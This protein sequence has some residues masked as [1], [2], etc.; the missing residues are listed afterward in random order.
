VKGFKFSHIPSRITKIRYAKIIRPFKE[1]LGKILERYRLLLLIE[2]AIYAIVFSVCVVL[3]YFSFHTYAFDLGIYNQV[4][5]TT[6]Y[7]GKLLFTPLELLANPSGSLFGVHFS[8]IFLG[9]M[10]IYA[11]YPDPVTL[12]ILQ[13]FVISLGALPVYLLASKR[14]A[15]QKWGLIFS[16]IYLLYPAVQ[17]VNWYD[18]HP[19]A[20]LLVSILF[21]LY[22]LDSNK[23][24]GYF[25]SFLLGLMCIEFAPIIFIFM[26]IYFLIKIKPWKQHFLD[27]KKLLLIL[28]T[29]VISSVWFILSLQ[30]IHIFNPIVSPMTGEIYWREIGAKSLLD[31]PVQ[32]FLHPERIM[33]ALLFDGWA[34]LGYI[35]VLL[36]AVGFLPLFEPLIG[37][38]VFP[39]LATALISNYRPF[40]QFA[41]QY[42]S[43]VIPFFI[44]GSILGMQRLQSL[45]KIKLSLKRVRISAG[46]LLCLSAIFCFISTP[47][48]SSPYNSVFY[49]SY[50]FPQITNHDSNVLKLLEFLPPNGSVITQ[51]NIFAQLSNRANA[52]L[53]PSNVHYP[54]GETCENAIYS[55][56]AKI[57]FIV[58]DFR[59]DPIVPP[60]MLAYAHN[61]GNFGVY[62]SNDG[63][64][65]LKRDFSGPP[66]YFQPISYSFNYKSN[67][68]LVSGEVV[69]DHDSEYGYA[70]LH[71]K[72]S[73][74]SDFWWGPAVFLPP[75]RYQATFS[76]KISNATEGELVYL[77]ISRWINNVSIDYLGTNTTGNDLIFKLTTNESNNKI[78]T[79]SILSS[80][81]FTAI[82]KYSKFTVN[83]SVT[84]FGAY[85]FRGSTPSSNSDIFFDNVKVIQNEPSANLTLQVYETF[86]AK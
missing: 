25:I 1:N 62:A 2:M 45:P 85:E 48:N 47:L 65:I 23:I 55:L 18:F 39:W 54:P 78:L 53:F 3:K 43:L 22:F 82:N 19:E 50:G 38:C 49:F 36:G 32:A 35:L 73:N 24:S 34:K 64:L 63:A 68:I 31:V 20:L 42:S 59:T 57:D 26:S 76:L 17:G 27:H 7:D 28:L 33:S 66:V 16:T 44:F 51:N 21:S 10:P 14:L 81:D 15:N 77:Y 86:T 29:I 79:S 11:I 67:F 8:P 6:L 52:Y 4:L 30:I 83:F 40:Y 46:I 70:F 12:L 74:S 84:D 37:I 69:Q 41:D 5:H 72:A 60:M 71:P 61:F 13:T 9:I 56:F 80:N 58:V 75:G